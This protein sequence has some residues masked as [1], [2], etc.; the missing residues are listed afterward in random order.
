MLG[1]IERIKNAVL[2]KCNGLN[3]SVISTDLKKII[4]ESIYHFAEDLISIIG[5]ISEYSEEKIRNDIDLKISNLITKKVKRKLFIDSLALQVTNDLFIE[6]YVNKKITLDDIDKN[7]IKELK[8]NKNSNQLNMTEDLKLDDIYAN[9]KIYFDMNIKP[10]I[11]E[12]NVLVENSE[13]LIVNSRKELEEKLKK[14]INDLDYEY[15]K[16]LKEEIQKVVSEEEIKEDEEGVDNMENSIDVLANESV[17]THE[18]EKNKFDVY[19]DMTLFN[20]VILSLNTKEEKLTRREEKINKRK[21]EVDTALEKTNKN[22][23]ANINRENE[24][25]QRKYELSQKEVIE[26]TTEEIVKATSNGGMKTATTIGLAMIAGGLT[27]KFVVAPAAAKFKNW[28]ENRKAAKQ[29]KD[30]IIDGEFEEVDYDE[31]DSE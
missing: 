11:I 24:L 22:I 25:S 28:R 5:N 9:V 26:T 10:K 18:E 30:D 31:S 27:Y 8:S 2:F 17:E 7:Y 29:Q 1:T 13:K 14:L 19:D 4:D 23:E 21:E 3:D 16:I 12:N 15:L 20:K 6:D